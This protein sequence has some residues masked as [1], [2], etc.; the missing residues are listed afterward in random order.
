MSHTP[1][2]GE[3][4]NHCRPARCTDTSPPSLTNR[5]AVPANKLKCKARKLGGQTNLAHQARCTDPVHKPAGLDR[6]FAAFLAL[7]VKCGDT[8]RAPAQ[9]PQHTCMTTTS[10]AS[11]SV[12]SKLLQQ[13]CAALTC[14]QQRHCLPTWCDCVRS[15]RRGLSACRTA[16]A[17]SPQAGSPCRPGNLLVD[18]RC[19]TG[20]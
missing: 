14:P 16:W 17:G 4:A 6:L 7:P 1:P 20:L 3:A 11:A 8:P 2:S 10:A 18:S 9:L 15:C 5:Q 19:R 12:T 13:V